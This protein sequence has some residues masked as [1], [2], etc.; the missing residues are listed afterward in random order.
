MLQAI[1][2]SHGI[3]VMQWLKEDFLNYFDA[4]EDSVEAR[5]DIND[6]AEKAKLLLSRQT[7]DGLR[8]TG[9]LSA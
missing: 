8:I 3:I 9:K 7:L 2:V 5:T 4:W 1:M 6:D